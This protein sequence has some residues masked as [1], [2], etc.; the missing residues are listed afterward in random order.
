M[1]PV[2]QYMM[3]WQYGIVLDAHGAIYIIERC[4]ADHVRVRGRSECLQGCASS[5]FSL[6]N[7][8]LSPV[9]DDIDTAVSINTTTKKTVVVGKRR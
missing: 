8:A 5:G 6:A 1:I 7:G 9:P 2:L 3:W 4:V